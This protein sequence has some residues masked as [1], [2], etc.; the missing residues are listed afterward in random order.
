MPE[1]PL[2]RPGKA[3]LCSKTRC[4][5]LKSVMNVGECLL[6]SSWASKK[7]CLCTFPRT[8]RRK[9]VYDIFTG[10]RVSILGAV[11]LSES[12]RCVM[13]IPLNTSVNITSSDNGAICVDSPDWLRPDLFP[14][15]CV[16][17]AI[18]MYA[19][20]A[21]HNDRP[22]E[23]LAPGATH[24]SSHPTQAT[25]RKYRYSKPSGTIHDDRLE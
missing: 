20:T 18:M 19:E 6:I 16:A 7:Y 25:P 4:Y 13:S 2:V 1:D 22:F 8:S 12:L 23:F 5:R 15:H 14:K 11:L 3:Y 21:V 10:M 24:V 9:A 17:A